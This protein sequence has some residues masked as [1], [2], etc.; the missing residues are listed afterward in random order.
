MTSAPS[1]LTDA[2]TGAESQDDDDVSVS[3]VDCT[4]AL[5]VG[6]AKPLLGVMAA[7]AV[8]SVAAVMCKR[9]VLRYDR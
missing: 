6:V 8:E 3:S 5:P 7:V 4:A 1:E 2:T 9:S